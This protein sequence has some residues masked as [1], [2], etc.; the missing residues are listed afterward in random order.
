MACF[1]APAGVAIVTTI[2]RKVLEKKEKTRAK[3]VAGE[4]TD[5]ATGKWTRRLSWLNTMLWGG[6]IMLALE[7]LLRGEV[8]PWPPFFTALETP[9]AV[10]PLFR[11]IATY[12]LVMTAGVIAVWGIMVAVAELAE[13]GAKARERS[14]AEPKA[15]GRGA[16]Y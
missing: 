9:G 11:E 14:G 1:V 5:D 10:G 13:R 15:V 12:G 8:V 3:T 4:H 6:T 16:G 7:H 2:V